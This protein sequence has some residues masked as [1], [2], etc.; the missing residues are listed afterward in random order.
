MKITIV[1]P[2]GENEI[3]EYDHA[4]TPLEIM[5]E[6]KDRFAHEVVAC[7]VKERNAHLLETVDEDCTIHFHDIQNPYGNMAYQASLTMLYL[8]AVNE[9]LGKEV[10][11]TIANSLS[12]GLFTKIHSNGIN[13][14]V[15]KQIEDHMKEMVEKDIPI[16][17]ERMERDVILEY[18]KEQGSQEEYRLFKT[19]E[20]LSHAFMCEINETRNLFYHHLVP[21]T[22]F[23]KLFDLRRYRNGVLLR[24]PHPS[25]PDVVPEYQEQKKLYEAFSEET[26]WEHLMGVNFV[27][28]LNEIVKSEDIKDL[29]MLSEA[30]HEKKI[31]EIA[32]EIKESGKRIVLIAGPSSSGK[33]TFAKRLSIQLRVIG[34]KP[35]YLGTDDYFIDRA[36]MKTDENGEMDFESLSAVDVE[37]FTKQMNELLAGNKVDLPEYN[38]I[39]GKKEYGK[40]IT[41]IDASQPIVIEG[42]HGL[43]P[44]LTKGISDE[45]KFKIYI[46]PLTQINIDMHHSLNCMILVEL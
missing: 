35:L 22:K 27:A 45:E 3:R 1:L 4:M 17:E 29:I 24:F 12:K 44:E 39:I 8:T 25:N 18:L 37:L 13:D 20:D 7:R 2:N 34:L 31:A 33:T 46:S 41:S 9:V 5:E 42:I 11:V 43:N 6:F 21:S 14:E 10:K 23:L 38:F 40:R 19:A 30:L 32:E 16:K 28:D 36:D 15:V 26:H